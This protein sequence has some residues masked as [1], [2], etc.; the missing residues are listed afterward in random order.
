MDWL[1]GSD[2]LQYLN[3]NAGQFFLAFARTFALF[4]TTPLLATNAVSRVAKLAL[5]LLISILVFPQATA[6]PAAVDPFSAAYM[7]ILAGEA[8]LGVLT[9]FFVT[10]IFSVFGTAGQF[11]SYQMGFA[12]SSVYDALSQ[13]ENPIVGQYFNYIAILV[14]IQVNGF[15]KLFLTGIL[16][17]FQTVNCYVF[18]ENQQSVVSLFLKFLSL[19]FYYAFVIS[20][21]IMGTLFLVHIGMGLLTKAAPQMNLLAEGFPITILLTFI[22][23]F[24]LLP[25]LIN[26]FEGILDNSFIMLQDFFM[27]QG[28][29]Q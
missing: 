1:Y 5:A 17:S 24:F 10:I 25:Q 20:L 4:L 18:L 3:D 2:L 23:M 6:L 15:Q 8:L 9:G 22:L 29:V 12:A 19:L 7:L 27:Q 13:V 14:F 11:F 16:R 26:F 28:K 21:P